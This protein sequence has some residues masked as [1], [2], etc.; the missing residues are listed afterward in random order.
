MIQRKQIMPILYVLLR[1]FG[2]KALRNSTDSQL[3]LHMG[4]VLWVGEHVCDQVH[5]NNNNNNVI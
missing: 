1:L 2:I 4:C 3:W 5:V